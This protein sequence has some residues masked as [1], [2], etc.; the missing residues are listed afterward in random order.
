MVS[1]AVTVAPNRHI[2]L[3]TMAH[4]LTEQKARAVDVIAGA[5]ALECVDGNLV[6]AGTTPQLGDGGVTMTAGTYAMTDIALGGVGEKLGIPMSYL[7]RMANDNVPALDYNINTWLERDNRR[8][9]VRCLRHDTTGGNGVARAFLSDSYLRIDNLDVLIAALDGVRQAGVA[10]DVVSCDLTDRRLYVRVVSP[11]IQVMAPQLLRNYRSPFDG[12]RGSDLPVVSG[13]FLLTNSE[14]GFG[15]YKIAPWLRIEVCK[16]GQ[17]VDQG[18][19]SRRHV[20]S[21]I[22]DDDG[23][24]DPSTE[25]MQDL[26]KLIKSMTADA[27]R[28]YL[29]HD[30]VTREVRELEKVAGVTVAKPDDTIKIVAQRLRYTEEQQQGILAHF[31]Q[32]GDLSAGGIMQAVTSYARSIPDA[33]SAYRME[34][35][36]GQALHLAAAAA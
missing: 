3:N 28:A 8:F 11:E 1:P 6:I 17:T 16:N 33:D 2:D 36:A 20:G 35:T 27:V 18:S 10:A 14:T 9:L 29:D 21:R 23:I 15:K 13:G 31:I 25:T 30:F 22:T 24:I 5:G 4:M 19:H 26:L 34:T 7:R 12:R 32:G